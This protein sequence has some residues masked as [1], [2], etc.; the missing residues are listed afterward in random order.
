MTDCD[1]RLRLAAHDGLVAVTGSKT[2]KNYG[3]AAD[4]GG[5][6]LSGVIP[7]DGVVMPGEP[8]VLLPDESVPVLP[9][10]VVVVGGMVDGE[11]DGA[12]AV[13]LSTFLPHAPSART[14]DR[15]SATAATDFNELGCMEIPLNDGEGLN[16]MPTCNLAK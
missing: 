10:G 5:M 16:T 8:I 13:V 2:G 14:A 7:D 12:G 15:A 3:L 6:L 11:V 4:A 9:E 1:G